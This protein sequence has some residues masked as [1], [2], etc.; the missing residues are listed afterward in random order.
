[1][2]Q[3]AFITLTISML[4][5]AATAAAE[6]WNDPV[7]KGYDPVAFFTQQQA[8]HGKPAIAI[9]H[10]GG[11]FWFASEEHRRLFEQ[12]PDKYA[13]RF[14]GFCALGVVQGRLL[15]AD[16]EAFTVHKGRLYL[17]GNKQ[18]REKW[19]QNKN[20]NIQKAEKNWPEVYAEHR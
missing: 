7:I 11:T 1:M 9:N 6:P 10:D 15:D 3:F 5:M 18:I 2:R 19:R 12:N 8:V 17:N 4:F 14:G 13:P 16:P 20:E